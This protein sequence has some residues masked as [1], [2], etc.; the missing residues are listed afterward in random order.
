M[1]ADYL[2]WAREWNFPLRHL[3]CEIGKR[4]E[5]W[6]QRNESIK[7]NLVLVV[8]IFFLWRMTIE[9]VFKLKLN[10]IVPTNTPKPLKW[11][12]NFLLYLTWIS[13]T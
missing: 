2:G 12:D 13:N 6:I 10:Y 8:Q 4:C 1:L 7:R 9:E 5:M 3:N 11:N